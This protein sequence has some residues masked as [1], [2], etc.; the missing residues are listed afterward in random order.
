MP[1]TSAGSKNN[2]WIT[3]MR[4][5]AKAFHE[6]QAAKRMTRPPSSKAPPRKSKA[7]PSDDQAKAVAQ[8]KEWKDRQEAHQRE[9][10]HAHMKRSKDHAQATE[11][12]QKQKLARQRALK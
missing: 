7:P 11:A 10:S 2:A 3:Y 5:C 9:L 8:L 6:E 4:K 1:Q 12:G